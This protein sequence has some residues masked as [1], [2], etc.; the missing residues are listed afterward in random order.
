MALSPILLPSSNLDVLAGA[1]AARLD[2]EV[3]HGEKACEGWGG[4]WKE[5]ETSR[6]QGAVAETLDCLPMDAFHFRE[7]MIQCL[8]KLLSFLISLPSNHMQFLTETLSFPKIPSEPTQGP[9]A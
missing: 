1:P 5:P 4:S 6:H 3:T 9:I 2:C 8:I 7:N